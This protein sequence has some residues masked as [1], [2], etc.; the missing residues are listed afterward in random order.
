MTNRKIAVNVPYNSNR[1]PL[2]QK[3][4]GAKR[5]MQIRQANQAAAADGR[6]CFIFIFCSGKTRNQYSK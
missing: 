4:S 6:I 1:Q 5:K 3:A 2:S